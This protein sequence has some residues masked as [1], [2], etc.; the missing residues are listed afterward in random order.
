ML[1]V[2]YFHLFPLIRFA[3]AQHLPPSRGRLSWSRS[4]RKLNVKIVQFA[5]VGKNAAAKRLPLG[6]KLSGLSRLM[7]GAVPRIFPL[8]P[9][10]LPVIPCPRALIG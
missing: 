3:I 4:K 2:L 6:G 9:R 8:I 1:F 10:F 7:R 5:S